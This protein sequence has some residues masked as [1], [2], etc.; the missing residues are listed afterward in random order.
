MKHRCVAVFGAVL[1][2]LTINLQA[3]LAPENVLVVI[4]KHSWA[5]MTVANAF[6][7]LRRIPAGNVVYLDLSKL[8]SYEDCDVN[9]FREHILQPVLQEITDRNLEEQIF[10]IAY[11]TDVPYKINVKPDMKTKFRKTTTPQAAITGLTI[12]YEAVL[13]KNGLTPEKRAAAYLSMRANPYSQGRPRIQYPRFTWKG[14]TSKIYSEA[15]RELRQKKWK[16]AEKLFKKGIREQKDHPYLHYYLAQ[17]EVQ[18]KDLTGALRSLNNAVKYGWFNKAQMEREANLQPLKDN[19]EFKKLL[20][21][22]KLPKAEVPPGKSFPKWIRED[23]RFK[24]RKTKLPP[25]YLSILLAWTGGRGM[26]VEQAVAH[27]ERAVKADESKP[28]GTVY[29]MINGDIRSKTRQWGFDG[30][31]SALAGLGI[32]GEAINGVLPKNKESVAGC[33]IGS[34]GFN[35]PKSGSKLLPGAIAE[36]LTSFGGNLHARAGQTC[37]LHLIQNGAA[38]TSGTVTEPYAIQAKFPTPYIHYYYGTGSTLIESFYQSISGPYQLIVV[39]EPLCRIWGESARWQMRGI[40]DGETVGRDPQLQF[41]VRNNV[42]LE[43]YDLYLDGKHYKSVRPDKSGTLATSRMTPGWHTLGVAAVCDGGPEI[44]TQDQYLFEV[45]SRI[46]VETSGK[47]GSKDLLPFGSTERVT[48]T[49]RGANGVFL[50]CNGRVIAESDKSSSRLKLETGKLGCGAVTVWPGAVGRKGGEKLKIYGKPFTVKVGPPKP[51]RAGIPDWNSMKQGFACTVGGKTSVRAGKAMT[52]VL[53][54]VKDGQDYEVDGYLQVP[55][56]LNQVQILCPGVEELKV[57][58]EPF[59]I[60]TGGSWH[61]LPLEQG[62][63]R[64][65]I[66]GK[67]TGPAKFK[68]RLGTKGV[69]DIDPKHC[70]TD[71]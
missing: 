52:Q 14:K 66:K 21:R 19:D 10:C 31:V 23:P 51:A 55:G 17:A 48:V 65:T 54:G 24:D 8:Y 70:R 46:K 45:P 61:F 41:R 28:Q 40:K 25:H 32:K 35:W 39:G 26:S 11:S 47:P 56:G 6:I 68:M 18:Q 34:A 5:S 33:T 15:M 2:L 7:E 29:F 64:L 27:I 12:T 36:H 42:K 53:N 57:N 49:C 13:G 3:G 60:P 59:S 50:E 22:V 38:G 44:T 4:N 67:L 16:E 9:A 37:C 20:S 69:R 58:G 62:T 71:K 43:R 30:T 63:Y 1:L